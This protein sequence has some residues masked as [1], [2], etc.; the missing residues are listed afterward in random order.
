[1]LSIGRAMSKNGDCMRKLSCQ[2]KNP[3]HFIALCFIE[4]RT[5]SS[6]REKHELMKLIC[7]KKDVALFRCAY[8]YFFIKKTNHVIGKKFYQK[9]PEIIFDSKSDSFS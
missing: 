9:K 6:L 7:V 1:M 8:G 3:K 4:L 5:N 2:P